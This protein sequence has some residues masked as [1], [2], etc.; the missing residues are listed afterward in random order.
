MPTIG[1]KYPS[2]EISRSL[3]T[4]YP[5][6]TQ[7]VKYHHIVFRYADLMPMSIDIPVEAFT[8]DKLDEEVD[9]LV[10]AELKRLGRIK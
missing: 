5:T 10:E 2:E 3:L 7:E 9:K 8:P 1:K 6:L 4:E